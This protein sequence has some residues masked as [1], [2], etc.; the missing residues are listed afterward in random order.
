MNNFFSMNFLKFLLIL[1][2]ELHLQSIVCKNYVTKNDFE[3]I[4]TE[5][6]NDK[7]L[8]D[9][10]KVF[11]ISQLYKAFVD[12]EEIVVF[13]YYKN[14]NVIK[15]NYIWETTTNNH[16]VQLVLEK[17]ENIVLEI[18]C[19]GDKRIS[20]SKTKIVGMDGE[21]ISF[22]DNKMII[23]VKGGTTR[24]GMVIIN[25]NE[26]E[27]LFVFIDEPIG[28]TKTDSTMVFE[29]YNNG[30][31][32]VPSYINKIH[33]PLGAYYRGNI[34]SEHDIE[35]LGMGIISQEGIK[36]TSYEE[37]EDNPIKCNVSVRGDKTKMKIKGITSIEPA[38][39]HFWVWPGYGTVYEDVKSFSFLYETDAYIGSD[40]IDCFSK[41]NDDHIKL[42]ISDIR[43]KRFYTY[44]QGNGHSFQFGWGNYG[45]RKK[46]RVNDVTVY[47]DLNNLSEC[48]YVR[49]F[50]NWRKPD[51][52]NI[53]EDVCFDNIK[54]YGPVRS[55]L[56]IDND[57][58]QW[59][60]NP[61]I[62]D[63]IIKNVFLNKRPYCKMKL[64]NSSFSIEL[65]NFNLMNEN[66]TS[67]NLKD[68]ISEKSYNTFRIR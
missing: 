15:K 11:G 35:I 56:V 61:I 32:V 19:H 36:H 57:G 25:G 55:F 17:G 66:V 58:N 3:K 6:N 59:K 40:I 52:P 41:V 4:L 24:R 31:Y 49:S 5:R 23:K 51:F 29:G 38:M 43:V 7:S 20:Q 53:I 33:I 26:S 9:S 67:K 18:S 21:I 42:Y 54:F 22:T 2:L 37:G 39:Y 63:F 48:K 68:L 34:I 27:P 45:S 64:E 50:I 44:L 30:T 62:K 16:W 60:S 47:R 8:D 28:F 10:L 12:R 1:V 46:I 65:E 13:N 14:S